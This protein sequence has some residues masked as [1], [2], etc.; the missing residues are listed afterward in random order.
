MRRR[1]RSRARRLLPR[2]RRG[3]APWRR[4]FPALAALLLLLVAPALTHAQGAAPDSVTLTWTA[5]GDDSLLGTATLYDMRMAS[6]PITL[7]NWGSAT[8]IPGLP[9][10]LVSGTTQAVT[11]RGLTPGE[12]V[13][14]AVRTRDDAGNWSGLSNVVRWDGVLDSA[15]PAAPAGLSAAPAGST[16][17]LAWTANSEPDLSGYSVYRAPAKSGPWTKLNSALIGVNSYVD[18]TPPA[19]AWYE[20]TATDVSNNESARSAMVSA[21]SASQALAFGLQPAFPNPSR[22]SS[23]VSVPVM[24]ERSGVAMLEIVD[25][26]GH[27]VRRL[28]LRSLAPGA[29]QVQWD[30]RNDAGREVAPGAYRAWLTAGERRQSTRLVRL[31]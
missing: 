11:V 21:A 31:P 28:D 13:Y 17:E 1:L 30:G 8:G 3:R 16:V 6:T 9:A 26:G 14:F 19:G 23:P 18:A 2:R 20:V 10:P 22:G 7:S 27:T 5:P 15:P 24:I 4:W 12:T 25:A 29:Q